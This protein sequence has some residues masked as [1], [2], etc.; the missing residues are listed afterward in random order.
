MKYPRE[1]FL[2]KSLRW[3]EYCLRDG[4]DAWVSPNGALKSERFRCT[5]RSRR[6]FSRCRNLAVRGTGLCWRHGGDAW[7]VRLA[8]E[9]RLLEEAVR[10]YLYERGYTDE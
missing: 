7:E 10:A 2:S 1:T 3:L 5:A 6:A 8:G 9:A 4:T